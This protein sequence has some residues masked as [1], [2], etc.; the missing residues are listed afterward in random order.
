MR[1]QKTPS[2]YSF[3]HQKFWIV[4][5]TTVH[6]SSGECQPIPATFFPQARVPI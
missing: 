1:I 2:Y 5:N 4:D 3:S 6:L